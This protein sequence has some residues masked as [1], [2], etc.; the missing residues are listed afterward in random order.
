MASNLITNLQATPYPI[1]SITKMGQWEPFDLQI[2]RRQI[3]GHQAVNIFGYSTAIGNVEQAIWEGATTGGTDYV[4]PTNAAQLQIKS[5][6]ASDGTSLNVQILGLDTNFNILTENIALNGTTAVTSVNSY[7][8]VNGLY[9][10]N[11][12]NVGTIS[13]TQGGSTVYAYIN[14]GIGFT[15]MAVYTVPNGYTFYRYLESLNSSFSGSNYATVRQ[16]TTYN[17]PAVRTVNGYTF[18][19]QNDTTAVQQ[20]IVNAPA[21]YDGTV[22]FGFP[23]GSD[24]KWQAQTS[25][26]GV[27]GALSISIY[28]ILVQND[29]QALASAL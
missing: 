13:A 11:G 2:A 8:R 14:P 4:F 22:P 25:G 6:S 5:T 24:I 21:S 1:E 16:Q 15:Q 10:T 28:G 27:N 23:G 3:M 18:T 9:V 7:Y 19:H 26:G 17:T 29:G 20:V 12:S